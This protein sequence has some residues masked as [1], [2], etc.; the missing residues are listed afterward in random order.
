[1][2]YEIDVLAVGEGERSGD[3]IAIRFGDPGTRPDQWPV[4]VVDGGTLDSG[5]RLVDLIK[6][7]YGTGHSSRRGPSP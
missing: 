2:P 3:A 1:M 7:S 5:E 4:I 6:N